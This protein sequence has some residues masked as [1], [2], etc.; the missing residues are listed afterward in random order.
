MQID[1]FDAYNFQWLHWCLITLDV[2][3]LFNILQFVLKSFD[4][5]VNINKLHGS[6][7]VNKHVNN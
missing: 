5:D 7:C 4:F 6:D 3:K 1:A 2:N